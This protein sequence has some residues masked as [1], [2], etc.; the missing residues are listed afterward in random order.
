[1]TEKWL[2][3][4]PLRV[5]DPLPGELNDVVIDGPFDVRPIA[6]HPAAGLS[7]K[8]YVVE[9]NAALRHE[10]RLNVTAYGASAHYIYETPQKTLIAVGL[11]A[12]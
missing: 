4:V 9:I 6:W 3:L 11:N 10:L 8:G 1:M 2:I 7:H 12:A 5:T